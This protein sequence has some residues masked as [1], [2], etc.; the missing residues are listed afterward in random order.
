[1]INPMNGIIHLLQ[2]RAACVPGKEGGA[3]GEVF[4]LVMVLQL[5]TIW[6]WD[7]AKKVD[8]NFF[9]FII[10]LFYLFINLMITLLN[11][12]FICLFIHLFIDIAKMYCW[13]HCQFQ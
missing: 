5:H 3:G 10:N 11:N 4:K 12:L 9:L 7:K 13:R 8:N 1:M 2:S 6:S